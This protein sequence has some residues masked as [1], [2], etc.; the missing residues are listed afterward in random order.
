VRPGLR[1]VQ[2]RSIAGSVVVTVDVPRPPA[3][4][5]VAVTLEPLRVATGKIRVDR[6][7]GW[8]CEHPK[9]FHRF[10]AEDWAPLEG[11]DEGA[12]PEGT[13]HLAVP[14]SCAAILIETP[15]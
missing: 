7:L 2:V 14:A 3:V 5:R 13:F 15:E 4:T 11:Y 6:V 9:H 8:A 1:R 12:V 10:H